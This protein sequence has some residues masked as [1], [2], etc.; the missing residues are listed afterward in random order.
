MKNCSGER[1]LDIKST[2]MSTLLITN[3]WCYVLK[4]RYDRIIMTDESEEMSWKSLRISNKVEYGN[5]LQI[6]FNTEDTTEY[7]KSTVFT[8]PFFLSLWV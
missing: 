2:K 1:S 7:V 3:C 5:W 8:N 4:M 6:H